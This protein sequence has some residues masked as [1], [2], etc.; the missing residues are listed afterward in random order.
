MVGF[1]LAGVLGKKVFL[2]SG[3]MVHG[4]SVI[5]VTLNAMRL[6]RYKSENLQAKVSKA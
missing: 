5:L 3:M 6:L 4:L 2:V 1:L